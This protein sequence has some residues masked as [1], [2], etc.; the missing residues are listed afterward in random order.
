VP[1]GAIR[2]PTRSAPQTEIAA[3]VS[4]AV[5][6][7]GDDGAIFEMSIEHAVEAVCLPYVAVDR[8]R[9]FA[10]RVDSKMVVLSGHRSQAA[11]LPEQPFRRNLAAAYIL[12]Q[13]AADLVGE[14]TQDGPRLEHADRFAAVGRC[15]VDDRRHSV[16]RRDGKEVGLELIAGADVD[17]VDPV[18]QSRFLQEHRYLVAVR[19]RPVVK[20]DHFRLLGLFAKCEAANAAPGSRRRPTFIEF[21]RRT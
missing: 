1:L 7:A 6:V 12:R 11:H 15:V 17:R 4:N 19:R 14:V 2:T 10:W 3:H 20:V 18:I 9:N 16:V 21:M 8:V 5:A 13:E